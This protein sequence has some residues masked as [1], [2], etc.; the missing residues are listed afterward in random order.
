MKEKI[1]QIT[2]KCIFNDEETHRFLLER[3]WDNDENKKIASIIML[4]PSYADEL[5]YDFTSMRVINYLI[6]KNEFRGIYILNLYS[7]IERD[8]GKL[9][10]KLKTENR[11]DNLEYIAKFTDK[12]KVGRVYK[13]WGT[14]ESNITI[15]REI[16]KILINNGY[17]CIYELVDKYGKSTHPSRCTIVGEKK[18]EIKNIL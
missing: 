15:I 3:I 2:S 18:I 4:N 12:D 13:G 8:S 17:S 7:I 5:R 11:V 1:G 6:E 10:G 14:N 9:T 16:Q